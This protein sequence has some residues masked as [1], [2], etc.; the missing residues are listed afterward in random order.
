[1]IPSI[2]CKIKNHEILMLKKLFSEQKQS[3]DVFFNTVS[4]EQGERILECFLA[5]KGSVIFSGVGK[6]GIIA[7]KLAMTM[8]STGTKAF[9]LPPINA[10]HG[11]IGAVSEQDVFVFI[12]KG[13]ETT[14]LLNLLYY[15]KQ[16]K[17]KTMAWVSSK[18]SSLEKGCEISMYLPVERELCPFDLAP[19]T[20]TAIQLIFGDILAVA[21]MNYKSFTIQDYAK[22]HPAGSIGKKITNTVEDIMIKGGQLP[23]CH[24]NDKLKDVL[25]EFSDK[26]CGCLV[27]VDD[28][29]KVQGIFTDGDLRRAL[30]KKPAVILEEMMKNLMTKKFL[31]IEKEHLIYEAAKIMQKDSNKRVLVLPV[32]Q[33]QRLVG[34]LHMHD[35]VQASL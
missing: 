11:D 4:I 21:L 8:I 18:E 24:I 22:N 6:S 20:S 3:L 16:R 26:R 30:Q 29:Q 12:S 17:A 13:G 34:L 1:M 32:I 31:S 23:I 27:I 15:V 5:C 14:E 2:D 7:E 35:V 9:Y 19:T 10:L 28:E 33:E 25:I